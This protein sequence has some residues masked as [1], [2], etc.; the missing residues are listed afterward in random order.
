MFLNSWKT[1]KDDFHLS[2]LFIVHIFFSLTHCSKNVLYLTHMCITFKYYNLILI[3]GVID[4]STISVR[5]PKELKEE[6][7]KVNVDWPGFIRS[8]V[9]QKIRQ[10]KRESASKRIDEIRSKTVKGVFEAAES[11]RE[12]RDKV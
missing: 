12:D 9:E 5:I 3:I 8:M 1:V 10:V 2:K 4:M 7:K 6:M 11:I